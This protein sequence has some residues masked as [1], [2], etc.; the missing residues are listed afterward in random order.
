MKNFELKG[1]ASNFSSLYDSAALVTVKFAA[2]KFAS[3]IFILIYEYLMFL[4]YA[5]FSVVNLKCNEKN[6]ISC[7]FE[8]ISRSLSR[9]EKQTTIYYHGDK[10]KVIDSIIKGCEKP[11]SIAINVLKFEPAKKNHIGKSGIFVLNSIEVLSRITIESSKLIMSEHAEVAPCYYVY[12]ENMSEEDVMKLR[13]ND[14]E[15]RRKRKG[16]ITHSNEMNEILQYQYFVVNKK[17]AI[18]LLTFVWYTELKCSDPQ[19][20]EVNRFDKHSRTWNSPNFMIE[21]FGN[22]HG[23]PLVLA[24][25]LHANFMSFIR[26]GFTDRKI[27]EENIDTSFDQHISY[28]ALVQGRVRYYGL[29]INIIASLA[30]SLNF[31]FLINLMD[32]DGPKYEL[33]YTELT[34]DA[35]LE[36]KTVETDARVFFF[37]TQPFIFLTNSYAVP[38]GAPY[39]QY[40]KLILPFD[41]DTWKWIAVTF[42]AAFI[43][44]LLL[45]LTRAEFRDLVVGRNVSTPAL[46]VLMLFSGISQVTLPRRNFARYLVMMFILFSM[47]IRTAYQGKMFEFMQKDMRRREVTSIEEAEERKFEIFNMEKFKIEGSE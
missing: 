43:F 41:D 46:N 6:S 29:F 31:S 2:M 28:H 18:V 34:V 13:D 15:K 17:D 47:I 9:F 33:Y 11:E 16:M 5:E 37:F 20:I 30:K 10:S 14:I 1:N 27:H 40:Q 7:A 36:M 35:I 12:V 25:D 39:T 8:E 38:P 3:F 32:Y 19:L 4:C 23:C 26:L 24:V 45:K 21:K 44:I 22:L 42:L